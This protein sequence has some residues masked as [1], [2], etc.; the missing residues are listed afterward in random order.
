MIGWYIGVSVIA[1]IFYFAIILN[2]L[3]TIIST[4]DGDLSFL[5]PIRNYHEWETLNWFGI[6]V[7]TFLINILLLPYA[8]IYWIYKLFTWLFTVGR[9]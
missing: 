6:S 9:N 8:I 3:N 5:N 1:I 2:I 7:I 4:L